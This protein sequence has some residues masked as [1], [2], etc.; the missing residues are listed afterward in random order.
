[1]KLWKSP[2]F[3]LGIFLMLAVTAALIAPLVIDWGRY[4]VSIENFGLRVTGREVNVEGPISVRLF[5]W[6]RLTLDKIRVANP[7]AAQNPNFAMIERV[8]VRLSLAGFFNGNVQVESIEIVKPV[9]SFERLAAGKGTWQM[10]PTLLSGDTKMLESVRLDRITVADGTVDLIDGLRGGQARI[11][12]LNAQLSAPALAGPWRMRGSA[13]FGE[14]LVDVSFNTGVWRPAEDLKFGFRLSPHDGPGLLYAFDGASTPASINGTLLIDSAQAAQG[15]S[16]P[17]GQLRPLV[18]KSKVKATF[19]VVDFEN[20]EISP[21]DAKQGGNILSGSAKIA[22]GSEIEVES[23]LKATRFDLDAI[24]GAQAR[25]LLRE[26]SGLSFLENV[27]DALPEN[28]AVKTDVTVTSLVAGGE[29]LE[30]VKVKLDLSADAIRVN[31]LTGRMPGQS[32]ALFDGIFIVTEK[33]PQLA[34][35]VAMESFNLRDLSKWVWPDYANAIASKW[36]GSRG[37]LKLETRLD[38]APGN[39]RLSDAEFSIDGALGKGSLS[40]ADGAPATINVG[41]TSDLVDIDNFLPAGAAIQEW[42]ALVAAMSGPSQIPN[43]NLNLET[44]QLRLN[45]AEADSLTADV[46]LN[47]QGLNIR[48][49]EL[50]QAGDAQVKASGAMQLGEK[51]PKGTISAD[52]KAQDPRPLLQFA[53]LYAADKEPAWANA[54]GPSDLKLI[55]DIQPKAEAKQGTVSIQGNLGALAV[56]ADFTAQNGVTL[57]DTQFAGAGEVKSASSKTIGSLI[58]FSPVADVDAPGSVTLTMDGSLS[59]G[60]SVDAK[61]KVFGAEIQYRG[62]LKNADNGLSISG[63]TGILTDAPQVFFAALG[64]AGPFGGLYSAEANLTGDASTFTLN[65]IT[66]LVA[67]ERFSGDVSGSWGGAIK[68]EFAVGATRLADILAASFLPWNGTA[69]DLSGPF[70]QKLPGGLTGEIWIKPKTLALLDGFDVPEAQI[71]ITAAADNV[72][73]ALAGKTNEGKDVQFE[74]R[75]KQTGS[76]QEVEGKLSGEFDLSKHL[77]TKDNAPALDGTMA[78][79]FAWTGKGRT[80]ASVLAGLKGSGTFRATNVRLTELDV[81]AFSNSIGNAS[82]ALEV[83]QSL[84]TLTSRS[85]YELGDISGSVTMTDGNAGFL[86]ARVSSPEADVVIKP[87]FDIASRSLDLGIQLQIKT[88]PGLPAVEMAY[89]GDPR[90]LVRNVDTSVL[91]ST[92]GMRILQKGMI[93]LERLQ[94]EQQRILE[95]EER[96]AKEDAERLAAWEA[97]RKEMQRR[98]REINV[99]RQ[100]WTEQQKR[101]QEHTESIA[102]EAPAPQDLREGSPDTVIPYGPVF[103]SPEQGATLNVPAPKP[104]P[105]KPRSASKPAKP[106][107][108]AEPEIQVPVVLVPPQQYTPS[109]PPEPERRNNFSSQRN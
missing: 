36:T 98:V 3:Y 94:K 16:D 46:A 102:P 74:L 106:M 78:I 70:S 73:L 104:K 12:G 26:G 101:Q 81:K 5:P 18:F 51:G 108:K 47:A 96:Q 100:N 72:Q 82:T 45:G 67:G 52:V 61:A 6:P 103:G 76:E 63:R 55:Y 33:G 54:L 79:E 37:H 56:S 97:H 34:G 25:R 49:L 87:L 64:W 86:P 80:P 38:V 22:L 20:I 7:Q 109:P 30:N 50:R 17:E 2:V 14:N 58:G 53:G 93:E 28:V 19:D 105:Q 31:E 9:L 88:P 83:K 71:G 27:V 59:Q 99:H 43:I 42:N 8:D 44:Q 15:K 60:M 69:A 48:R 39:F 11:N 57:G 66:G 4:R 77:F 89:L 90:Q 84:E 62:T 41:L 40:I 68:G 13:S 32:E 92:L 21:K 75:R 29:A 95:E 35:D 10:K 24:A 85:Q 65:D 107:V 91:E 23:K 1:M